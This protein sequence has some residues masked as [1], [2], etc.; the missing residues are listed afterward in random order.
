MTINW[1]TDSW[2]GAPSTD[3][4]AT[5]TAHARRHHIASSVECARRGGHAGSRAPYKGDDTPRNGHGQEREKRSGQR[6]VVD[7][8]RAAAA[9][10]QNPQLVVTLSVKASISNSEARSRPNSLSQWS[11]AVYASCSR[12]PG[13]SYFICA[14]FCRW[15]T[16]SCTRTDRS[17]GVSPVQVSGRKI[18]LVRS[19]YTA[20]ASRPCGPPVLSKS[21][22]ST[23]RRC[24]GVK[25]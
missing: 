8:R 5:I 12:A 19:S 24:A 6:L 16:I 23:S 3:T 13:H 14:L 20:T 4:A 21:D 10:G 22:V 18:V 9:A 1:A 17:A 11:C 25:A 15:C 7:S 2:A